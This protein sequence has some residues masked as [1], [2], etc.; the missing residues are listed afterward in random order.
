MKKLTK[1][2]AKDNVA[3]LYNNMVNSN[4]VP[5]NVELTGVY[6]D[7]DNPYVCATTDTHRCFNLQTDY[8][9]N[10]RCKLFG[11][12]YNEVTYDT[13][14]PKFGLVQKCEDCKAIIR[15]LKK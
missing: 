15:S 4:H 2:E 6:Y 1:E 14:E 3:R 9:D 12:L 11:E 8:L 13:K 7:Q 10:S 5:I